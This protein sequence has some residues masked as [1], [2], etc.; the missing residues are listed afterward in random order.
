MGIVELGACDVVER[1]R[2]W[3]RGDNERRCR[4]FEWRLEIVYVVSNSE[5]GG[6]KRRSGVAGI[7][8]RG[9]PF[10]TTANIQS[11]SARD[12]VVDLALLGRQAFPNRI[13]L[14]PA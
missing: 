5:Q 11:T 6:K 3:S 1:E 4:C 13:M 9:R 14:P 7:N 2:R 8:K 12:R 10:T